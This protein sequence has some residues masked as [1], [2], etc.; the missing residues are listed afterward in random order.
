MKK[1]V[2][3]TVKNVKGVLKSGTITALNAGQNK[4]VAQTLGKETGKKTSKKK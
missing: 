1:Q 4:R 3:G 2:K